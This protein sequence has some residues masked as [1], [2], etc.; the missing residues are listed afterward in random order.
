MSELEQKKRRKLNVYYDREKYK[1]FEYYTKQEL[2]IMYKNNK[3]QKL[4]DM[5]YIEKDNILYACPNPRN[6]NFIFPSCDVGKSIFIS[7]AAQISKIKVLYP[8]TKLYMKLE[9]QDSFIEMKDLKNRNYLEI[10]IENVYDK[11]TSEYIEVNESILPSELTLKNLSLISSDYLYI[12]ESGEDIKFYLTKEREAFFKYFKNEIENNKFVPICGPESIGKTSTILG[13]FSL[14]R[15][16]YNYFYTNLKTLDRYKGDT[17]K[18]KELIIKELY[19]CIPIE[20][21]NKKLEDIKKLVTEESNNPIKLISGLI[22]KLELMSIYLIIDQYKITFDKDYN[23]LKIIQ[24]IANEKYIRIIL[25]SSMN[26]EDVKDSIVTTLSNTKKPGIFTLDYI[27]VNSLVKCNGEG[28]GKE[29][30]L[31]LKNYGNI[32]YYYFNILEEK[33]AFFGNDEEFEDYF[34]N[35]MV[36]YFEDRLKTYHNDIKDEILINNLLFLLLESDDY[37]P[38][39]NFLENEKLI[40]FRFFNFYY[41]DKNFFKIKDIKSKDNIKIKFQC[42]K[43]I[44]FTLLLYQKLLDK[45]DDK[46][47]IEKHYN[48]EQLFFIMLW[49]TRKNPVIKGVNIVKIEKIKS[50]FKIGD[51]L[52]TKDMKINDAILFELTDENAM[53]FDTGI[54]KKEKDGTFALYLF[55]VT[56]K[57]NSNER[58]TYLML[59]DYFNFFKVHFLEKLN[60]N[61]TKNYFSYVFDKSE[62]DKATEDYLL[63]YDI[64]FILLDKINLLNSINLKPYITKLQVINNFLYKDDN[65]FYVFIDKDKNGKSDTCYDYLLKKRKIFQNISSIENIDNQTDSKNLITFNY[66]TER[67]K[68]KKKSEKS[69]INIKLGDNIGKQRNIKKSKD[70]KSEEKEMSID[71]DDNEQKQ[72][73]NQNTKKEL[74][75]KKDKTIKIINPIKAPD[76]KEMAKKIKEAEDYYNKVKEAYN[77]WNNYQ[78]KFEITN[79]QKEKIISDYFIEVNDNIAGI[80]YEIKNQLNYIQKFITYTNQINSLK[81]FLKLINKG[82][83][84]FIISCIEIN[85]SS[86]YALCPEYNSFIINVTEK[87]ELFYLD[88]IKRKRI[89][90]ENLVESDFSVSGT[91]YAVSFVRRSIINKELKDYINLIDNMNFNINFK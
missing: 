37:I 6:I 40:P 10:K 4:G 50:L 42:E 21:I 14:N 27:Y 72:K 88:Y 22:N 73:E 43:Y 76:I 58:L 32:Y 44:K 29:C 5:I 63:K 17:I 83:Y 75:K 13:F 49:A 61:I 46:K 24:R 20:D 77:K 85:R 41:N 62:R 26:E 48:L 51:N 39:Q 87:N 2:E 68:T 11:N 82:D 55:Q 28:L 84:D 36:E 89:N 71:E 60:I 7:D 91:F 16:L 3:K 45:I 1:F 79:T 30:K 38:I 54:L 18:I 90:L 8:D 81:N 70:E 67:H 35:K 64:N 74:K 69:Q 80:S 59:N 33:K 23:E 15:D 12:P 66:E 31:L 34:D 86:I 52:D 19:H 78:T 65:N 47:I 56:K 9:G 57:K 25:I 53:A